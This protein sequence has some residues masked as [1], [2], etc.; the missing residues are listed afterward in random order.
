MWKS[1]TQTF[2]FFE[3]IYP[4][5]KEDNGRGVRLWLTGRTKTFGGP[6]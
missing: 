5:N 4:K 1:K 3:L 2:G 6:L